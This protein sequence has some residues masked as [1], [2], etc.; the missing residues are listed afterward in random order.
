MF[1]HNTYFTVKCRLHY[2]QP[3]RKYEEW[4]IAPETSKITTCGRVAITLL[5]KK[6]WHKIVGY[7]KEIKYMFYTFTTGLDTIGVTEETSGGLSVVVG[8]SCG[9]KRQRHAYLLHRFRKKCEKRWHHDRENQ[10]EVQ[11]S[12]G[13]GIEYTEKRLWHP[14][15][16]EHKNSRQELDT[17]PTTP[18]CWVPCVLQR[19]CRLWRRRQD[20][21]CVSG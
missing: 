8:A 11:T 6:Y 13:A 19:S 18:S 4:H 7:Q 16:V 15:D 2:K 14:L 5:A 20:Q 17:F 1:E 9:E 10:Q 3:D 21:K 12:L